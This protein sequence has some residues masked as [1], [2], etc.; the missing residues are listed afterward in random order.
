MKKFLLVIDAQEGFMVNGVTD[1][2]EALLNKLLESNLF[3]CVISSVY[4]N[5][6]GSNITRFAGWDKLMT[7]QEQKV[8]DVVAAHTHHYVYKSTYSAYSDELAA[9]LKKD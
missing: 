7:A 8:T 3:D 1:Q 6:P 4:Q 9:L 5:F 2:A